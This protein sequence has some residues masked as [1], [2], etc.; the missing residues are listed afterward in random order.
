MKKQKKERT[1][2]YMLVTAG[3]RAPGRKA[4]GR[5]AS[6]HINKLLQNKDL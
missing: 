2:A 6:E 3:K 4:N 5:P 1:H